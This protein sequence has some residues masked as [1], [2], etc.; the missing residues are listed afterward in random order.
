[1]IPAGRPEGAAL[2]LVGL[3]AGACG[4]AP[5]PAVLPAQPPAQARRLAPLDELQRDVDALLAAPSLQPTTWGVLVK[6]LS[7]D[8]TIYALNAG[9]LL[10]P[11]STMKV[12]TL[13]VAAERLGWDFTYE[14]SLVGGGRIANGVLDGPLVV[15]G[16]G[17]P[18]IDNWDGAASRLFEDWAGE[19]KAAGVRTVTGNLIGDDNAFDD[20][21]LGAGWMWDDL[22]R[23]F[24]TGVGALQFNE[25]TAQLT[26]APGSNVGDSAIVTAAPAGA[27]LVLHSQVTTGASGTP[28]ALSTERL[29]GSATLEV[30]GSVPLGARPIVRN[31]AALNPTLY[32]A[33]ELRSALVASGIEVR[34]TAMDIDDVPGRPSSIAGTTLVEHRSPPLSE[35]A[36]TMMK[37]SQN[38]YAET[39][40]KTIGMADGIPTATGGIGAVRSVL[41]GWGVAGYTQADGSGLSRYNVATPE[42]LVA[43]LAHVER[44]ET[45]GPTFRSVLP[46][47]GLDGT[48]EARMKGTPAEGNAR[49][50]TGTMTGARAMAGFLTTADGEPLVFSIVGNNFGDGVETT[51]AAAIDAVVVRLARFSR[52]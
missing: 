14:T 49:A 45:L 50:K 22:D 2:F 47:A 16:R 24:A 4:G 18:T 9:K 34:G 41:A 30:R 17:D 5:R 7:R 51:A 19:L 33:N 27:A 31:T 32:F 46:I 28:A 36:A 20:E 25:N 26:I 8:E 35:M 12:L 38:L 48:L 3:L 39:L 1:M 11:S 13:A 15:V 40:L 21:P 52:R 6:S 29:P 10:L 43:V 44:D 42:A 37:L 23:S